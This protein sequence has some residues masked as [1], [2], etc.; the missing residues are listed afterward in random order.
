LTPGNVPAG[1][2]NIAYFISAVTVDNVNNPTVAFRVTKNG[3]PIVFNKYTGTDNAINK[4]AFVDNGLITGYAG[5]PSFLIAFAANQDGINPVVDYNNL[6]NSHDRG[7]P[8]SV[9]VA[10]I[11]LN[12]NNAGIIMSGPDNVTGSYTVKLLK[13][14]TRASAANGGAITGTVP[15]AY[16]AGSYMRAI[17]L[18]GRLSQV[19]GGVQVRRPAT[20]VVKQVTPATGT[21]QVR[22]VVVDKASC[23]ECHEQLALHGS[24]RVNE[25]QLCVICHN[26]NLG[27]VAAGSPASVSWNFKDMIHGIHSASSAY[28]EFSEVTYP[29]DLSHCTKCHLGT[30]YKADLPAGVLLSTDSRITGFAPTSTDNVVS[31]TAAACGRCHNDSPAVDHFRLQGGDVGATRAEATVTAPVTTMAVDIT[32]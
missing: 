4:R 26:P 17:G 30:T 1:L 31:P 25:V 24:N 5:S 2:D 23:L 16:P 8:A 22:R 14:V 20:S 7:Q 10:E 29:G 6:G 21:E 19:V 18:Q 3:T 28:G 15:A 11:F 9:S 12:D 32:P 27:Q 13:D